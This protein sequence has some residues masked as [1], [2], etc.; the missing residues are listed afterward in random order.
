MNIVI[1]TTGAILNTMLQAA[2]LT[3]LIWL[4][5]TLFRTRINAATR[6]VIWW[7]ALAAVISLP[8]IPTLPHRTE[9]PPPSSQAPPSLPAR[10]A[11]PLEAPVPIEAVTV[12]SH[13]RP[14]W[15][16]VLLASWGAV[17]LYRAIRLSRSYFVLRAIKRRATPFGHPLPALKRPVRL[18]VSAEISSPIAVGFLHPAIILP[19]GL[20]A[21]LTPH[22]RN[23]VL[24]HESAHLARYDDWSN[25][26]ARCLGAALA[27]HPVVWWILRRIE[28][29]REIACDE[30]V[31][32][33]TSAPHAY[34]EGLVHMAELKL[35]P[36]H[37][38]LAA[39]I[40]TQPSRLRIR[41]ELLLHRGRAFSAAIARVPLAAS[42]L[43]VAALAIAG[44]FAPHWIAFAQRLEFEVASVKRNSTDGP[45]DTTPRRSGDLF[46]MHNIQPYSAIY[47]AYHLHGSYQM[48]GYSRL[49]E[50]W[51]W[52]DIDARVGREA[53]E[54]EMRL[55]LQSLLEDRFK[56]KVHRETRDIP[57][58]ELVIAKGKPKLKPST[59]DEP[60]NVKIENKEYGQRA[61]TCGTSLWH[62]GAH[63]V[64]HAAP[65]DTIVATLS[66]VM[67]APVVDRTG[68]T[69][70]YDLHIR[71]IQ[72]ERRLKM[73]P[74]D[75][76][77][78][79]EQAVQ[80]ELGLKLEKGKGPVE[81]LVID[82]MEKPTEN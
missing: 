47:Y 52:Y 57:E 28:R 10:I 75:L 6:Y 39:G 8:W 36:S 33:Q 63:T 71:F 60:L 56:L 53:T 20:A 38:L 30:W 27:L 67:R 13:I 23:H 21:Q 41:I 51:N 11:P 17:L 14:V 35:R 62:D 49:P 44:T 55:M 19:D 77:P 65:T 42:A 1:V 3:I 72:E 73:D 68:L 80:E 2:A 9:P 54:D 31:M 40:Y 29:D 7:I 74:E 24:L 61:G 25:L 45:M 16:V 43:A 78:T 18:L 64:C 50:G 48:A 70:T 12:T 66:N 58:Y 81:V 15:P 37:S 69:G 46:M 59:G 22:E 79:L 26:V 5:V 32:T 4:A 76:G 82:H 34:A